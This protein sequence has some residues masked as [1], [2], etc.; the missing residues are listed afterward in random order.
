MLDTLT[1][2][3]HWLDAELKLLPKLVLPLGLER[4]EDDKAVGA[5]CDPQNT[6]PTFNHDVSATFKNEVSK[7]KSSHFGC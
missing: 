1:L 7:T 3:D 2:T 4:A 5:T 6:P